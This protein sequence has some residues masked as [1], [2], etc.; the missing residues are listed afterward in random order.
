M[1][2]INKQTLSNP[3]LGGQKSTWLSTSLWLLFFCTTM[4]SATDDMPPLVTDCDSCHGVKGVSQG[5]EFPTIAGFSPF[6]LDESL[7]QF[8]TKARFCQD[9]KYPAGSRQGQVAN[10]CQISEK[11]TDDQVQ[12]LAQYYA[13]QKFVA[14]NQDFD[15]VKAGAGQK[16][17]QR[18]CAKCHANGGGDPA[19]DAGLLAGQWMSYLKLTFEQYDQGSREQPEKMAVKYQ[20]LSAENKQA[21]LHY[22]ASQQD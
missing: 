15:P 19:D 21:L 3:D 1:I 20:E 8:K 17:H 5:D 6:Y 11:L 9:K 7:R 12:R 14:A 22:Y 2:W 16:V 18:Y 13:A 4:A 10:M